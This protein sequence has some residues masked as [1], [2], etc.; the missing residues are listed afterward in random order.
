[1]S[2]CRRITSRC[3][4]KCRRTIRTAP[5]RSCSSTTRTAT[6]QARPRDAFWKSGAGGFALI[7]VPSSDLVIY[8]MGGH[9]GQYD[10]ALT[11]LPQPEPGHERDKWQPNPRT[12]FHEGSMGGDDGIRRVLEM[13]CAAVRE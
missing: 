10:P 12:P 7:I 11:G 1:G 2:S 3:A 9:N 13:V 4:T 8:K 5:T 6:W